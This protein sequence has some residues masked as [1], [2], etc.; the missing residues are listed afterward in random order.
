M[1]QARL[2][3]ITETEAIISK[4]P[5]TFGTFSD[6]GIARDSSGKYFKI[7]RIK[8]MSP[9]L[10]TKKLKGNQLACCRSK[11]RNGS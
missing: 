6:K 3:D 5:S 7:K 9:L 1:K 8:I 10:Q 2:T 11:Q 4:K